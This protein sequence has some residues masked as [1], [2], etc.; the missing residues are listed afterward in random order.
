MQRKRKR[1]AEEEDSLYFQIEGEG[2]YH[3]KKRKKRLSS[4]LTKEEFQDLPLTKVGFLCPHCPVEIPEGEQTKDLFKL[5]L[6]VTKSD[7][8]SFTTNPEGVLNAWSNGH[9]K[10]MHPTEAKYPGGLFFN[11]A[12]VNL[13]DGD[14]NKQKEDIS[15]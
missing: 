3:E 7:N 1:D 9:R 2:Q 11:K 14:N 6:F 10:L 5:R 12:K 13:Q 15:H 4:E 8:R